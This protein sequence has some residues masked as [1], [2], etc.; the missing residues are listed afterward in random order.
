[1]AVQNHFGR[2]VVMTDYIGGVKLPANLSQ[3]S[4]EC[5]AAVT[6]LSEHGY[7]LVV[8]PD[9]FASCLRWAHDQ[10]PKM[11]FLVLS[12]AQAAKYTRLSSG[13]V[14]NWEGRY[15]SGII[16]GAYTRTNRIGVVVGQNSIV[17]TY[18]TFISMQA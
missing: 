10:F 1:M 6:Y 17:R 7:S 18:E 5:M 8:A 2:D 4:P 11:H 14:R 15:A 12:T 3:P 13:Y 16:V 9:L